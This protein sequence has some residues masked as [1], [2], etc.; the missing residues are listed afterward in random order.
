MSQVLMAD[1]SEH[2]NELLYPLKHSREIVP[3]SLLNT[4]K[5][6]SM[7]V[8]KLKDCTT[9][10]LPLSTNDA[11]LLKLKRFDTLKTRN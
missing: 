7:V 10:Y 8:I 11:N 6:R 1:S 5:H 3:K 2:D 9:H 4:V